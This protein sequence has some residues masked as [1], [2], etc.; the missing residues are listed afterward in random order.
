M[1]KPPGEPK[2]VQDPA[3]GL[4]SEQLIPSSSWFSESGSQ[5]LQKAL[6]VVGSQ[7]NALGMSAPKEG[8]N[9]DLERKQ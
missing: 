5:A 4:Q 1:E 3:S 6:A 9:M 8:N 2:A 7:A